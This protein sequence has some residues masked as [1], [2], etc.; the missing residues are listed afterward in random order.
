MMLGL[1]RLYNGTFAKTCYQSYGLSGIVGVGV[2]CGVSLWAYN[3]K[4]KHDLK[5]LAAKTK[6]DETIAIVQKLNELLK[7]KDVSGFSK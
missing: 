2:I 3:Y 1:H 5:T 6:H 7:E 4:V